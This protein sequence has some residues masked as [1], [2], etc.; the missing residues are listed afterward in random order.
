MAKASPS[1][2]CS[3]FLSINRIIQQNPCKPPS[4]T[5]GK[6]I[7]RLNASSG[8]ENVPCG[9]GEQLFPRGAFS[10][11]WCLFFVI[12]LSFQGAYI[13]SERRKKGIVPPVWRKNLRFDRLSAPRLRGH[14][15]PCSL[16]WGTGYKVCEADFTYCYRILFPKIK[17]EENK[18]EH[19]EVKN[20]FSTSA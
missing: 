13:C 16:F 14:G 6:C 10:F 1:G 7:D 8:E 19:F 15:T 5:F 20:V 17:C 11:A 12:F 3:F 9:E 2:G 4:R 18:K